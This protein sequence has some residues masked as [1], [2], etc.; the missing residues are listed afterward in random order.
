MSNKKLGTLID[1]LV[2]LEDK[3]KAESVKL[4]PLQEKVNKKREEVQA[5]M[6][7]EK[8]DSGSGKLGKVTV[9]KNKSIVI[10]NWPQFIKYAFRNK[11]DDLFNKAINKTA[12]MERVEAGKKVPGTHLETFRSIRL[13][14]VKGG[15]DK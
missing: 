12:Y 14:K 13:N 11:A 2:K 8:T 15:N 9:V 1:E 10:D 5:K 4:K 6:N 3:L 7:Q